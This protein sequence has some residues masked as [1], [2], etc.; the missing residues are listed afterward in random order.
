[1][2]IFISYSS[3]SRSIVEALAVDLEAMG[4]AIWFDRHLTGGLDWWSE[5][6]ESIRRCHLFLFAL[7]PEAQSSHACQL[8][9][10]YASAL[11]KRILP[12]MLADVDVAKLPTSL[13]RVQ[14]V[15]YRIQNKQQA[16]ALSKSLTF[17]PA[18][19][20]L[21]KPLPP[22]PEVPLSP[23]A[24][25][26]E[27]IEGATLAVDD[28]RS[29][30][31]RLKEYLQK[32]EAATDARILLASL[33]KRDDLLDSVEK[34]I[35]RLL[36]V[37]KVGRSTGKTR[38]LVLPPEQLIFRGH[39][40]PV[41]GVAYLPDNQTILT[42]GVD[43]T[44]RLWNLQTGKE[45]RQFLGHTGA[46]WNI[47]CSPDGSTFLSSSRDQTARLWDVATGKTLH[48]ISAHTDSVWGVAFSPDGSTLLTGS[49]DKTARL[50]DAKSGKQRFC[51]TGHTA[52]V[53][54]VVYAPDGKTV[55]TGSWDKS[56]RI[57]EVETGRE[58]H[59]LKG[60]QS[61][62]INVAIAPDGKTI[63]TSE[64]DG[65]VFLW[66]AETH[67]V[68]RQLSSHAGF[69]LAYA[70]DNRTIVIGGTDTKLHIRNFRTGVA[71]QQLEGHTDAITNIAC[72][73]DGRSV[74]SASTDKTVR[75]W[76]IA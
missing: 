55:A 35:T 69:G 5:I 28:Q 14:F 2:N 23:F 57:W 51:L 53:W 34:E 44:I 72:A 11:N 58:L 65:K 8:E 17:L 48:C 19:K 3:K 45:I 68:V 56:V 33:H 18:A 15:D 61:P 66:D 20:P 29:I 27:Q 41:F 47:A 9:Y 13:Q 38:N 75:L 54:G 1:M 4:Y 74:L 26:R 43:N 49:F 46:I 21:P 36:T 40:G 73:P 67:Q 71:L 42:G 6:L 50:W 63:V 16:L 25:M 76:N 64:K 39:E 70:A 32:P 22:P 10:D 24:K 59:Q 7:T 52:A 31:A 60:H 30:L 37:K 62:I 12:V